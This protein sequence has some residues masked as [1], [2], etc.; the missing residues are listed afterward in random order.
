M[1]NGGRKAALKRYLSY[2]PPLLA[3]GTS[4]RHCQTRS[5]LC[6]VTEEPDMSQTRAQQCRLLGVSGASAVSWELLPRPSKRRT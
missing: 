2:S 5:S 1:Q 4:G 6:R 3:R